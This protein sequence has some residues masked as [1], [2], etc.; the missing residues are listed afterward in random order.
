MAR[1]PSDPRSFLAY[2]GFDCLKS[3][4]HTDASI[5]IAKLL[6]ICPI[7]NPNSSLILLKCKEAVEVSCMIS[8]IASNIK[9]SLATFFLKEEGRLEKIP[10]AREAISDIVRRFHPFLLS[11]NNVEKT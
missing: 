4:W 5:A 7:D 8:H 10:Y 2:I 11:A 1:S 3:F 6:S 9:P